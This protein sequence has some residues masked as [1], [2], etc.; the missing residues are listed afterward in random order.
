M[1]ECLKEFSNLRV[2]APVTDGIARPTEVDFVVNEK[3]PFVGM[4][5]RAVIDGRKAN[6][7]TKEFKFLLPDLENIRRQLAGMRY[8]ADLD[9]SK[10][11]HQILLVKE[12]QY[13]TT[14]IA[15]DRFYYYKRVMM[16]IQQ[17][18]GHMQAALTVTLALLV[19]MRKMPSPYLD[20]IKFAADSL[21]EL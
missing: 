5:R 3:R 6:V 7:N 12:C 14:F 13:L 21:H 15:N 19:D 8:V 10:A 11:F 17:S 4:Q 16:G 1:A 18:P 20:D 9:L 2:I